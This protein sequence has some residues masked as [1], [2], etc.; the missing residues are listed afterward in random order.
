MFLSRQFAATCLAAPPGPSLFCQQAVLSILRSPF[1]VIG[2]P[3][4]GHSPDQSWRRE[5][6]PCPCSPACGIRLRPASEGRER[7]RSPSPSRYRRGRDR[8]AHHH[9]RARTLRRWSTSGHRRR[10]RSRTPHHPAPRRAAVSQP[11]ARRPTAF[12]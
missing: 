1:V 12:S 7:L 3:G 4:G 11:V 10:H 5:S 9:C 6:T 2:L 8:R